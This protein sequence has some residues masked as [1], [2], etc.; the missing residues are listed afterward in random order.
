MAKHDIVVV[1]SRPRH[2]HTH[3]PATEAQT[4]I[5]GINSGSNGIAMPVLLLANIV[6]AVEYSLLG[7]P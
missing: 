6:Y 1:F 7:M 4:S 2:P 3:T 5:F